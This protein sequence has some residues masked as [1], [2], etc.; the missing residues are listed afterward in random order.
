[1]AWREQREKIADQLTRL[2]QLDVRFYGSSFIWLSF[3]QASGV[4]RGIATTFLMARWLDP[5]VLGQ[6]RY[7]LALFGVAGI[8]AMSGMSAAVIRGVAKGDGIV[9]RLALVRILRIAPLGSL[10]LAIGGVER[11]MAGEPTV[12]I[13]L[14]I[15]AIAFTPYSASGLYGSI[16]TGQQKIKELTRI[17]V[18]NNLLFALAFV[19]VL[20]LDRSLLAITLAY[21]GFDLLFRGFLTI[22]ELS[23][24]PPTGNAADHLSLGNHLSG[25]GVF[26]VIAAQLDQ[27]LIQRFAGYQSLALYSVVSVIPEQIK[28][29]VNGISGT[30]LQR[31]SRHKETE[32][33]V[34]ATQRHFWISLGGSVVIVAGYAVVAPIALPWLFPKYGGLS[35]LPSI[36]YALGL[37]ALPAAI[38]LNYLQA[39]GHIR[40]LWTFYMANSALQIGTNLA[41]IPFFGSWGA[42]WS[43][44]ITRIAGL[45]LSYPT[46]STPAED[47]TII[48]P[49]A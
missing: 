7:V 29:M 47:T 11:W 8:F 27:V 31:L 19:I 2:L 15:S 1:M 16:L 14:F 48:T 12:A 34:R 5:V 9:A 23:R 6:F 13:A 3:G 46:S 35:V 25:I 30:L 44:T 18:L 45:P 4:I 40:R 20:R 32:G 10:G 26:Q 38:G 17:A 28:D 43:K 39:H 49:Q 36:V 37:L 22:R 21:F 33:H 24:L 42:I 41:L